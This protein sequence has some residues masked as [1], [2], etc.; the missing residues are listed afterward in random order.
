MMCRLSP[1]SHRS[2]TVASWI[3]SV[4]LLL[5]LATDSAHTQIATASLNG[6]VTDPSGAVIPGATVSLKNVATN[7]ERTTST[8]SAGNYVLVNINPGRYTLTVHKDGFSTVSQPVV[9]K[10][11]LQSWEASSIGVR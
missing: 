2:W 7:V 1:K 5:M 9:C 6:T 11:P 3:F 10:P 8:N 4:A